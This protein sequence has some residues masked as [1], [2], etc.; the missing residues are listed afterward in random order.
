MAKKRS[1]TT[2]TEKT[3]TQ[4]ATDETQQTEE[5][6]QTEETKTATDETQTGDETQQ[7]SSD[8]TQKEEA[9]AGEQTGDG[10][11]ETTQETGGANP[12]ETQNDPNDDDDT[13]PSDDEATAEDAEAPKSYS[14][15][16]MKEA[17]EG[18]G[19]IGYKLGG[20]ID[21]MQPHLA[22]TEAS[23]QKSQLKLRGVIN[24][25]LG[26]GDS[27]FNDGM[28]FLVKAVR[29]HRKTV[30]SE[31]MVFRGFDR[32]RIGRGERQKLET[33]ISLLLA[34]ADVKN[35]KDVKKSVDMKVV[36]RFVS[37]NDQQQ[38]LQS[39]YGA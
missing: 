21:D 22:Q 31:T 11:G 28:K 36:Y 32:L 30:F 8:D 34:T 9:G 10:S 2:T 17:P 15:V 12:D 6:S 5:Q 25:V 1:S 37:D 23:L 20:Y 19:G 35:P 33:L 14:N 16:L 13:T 38:K 3:E 29:D 26:L 39:Y 7:A 27:Q 4:Q 18:M 24:N